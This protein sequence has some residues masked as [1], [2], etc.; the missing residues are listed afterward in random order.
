MEWAAVAP[1][2]RN[3]MPATEAARQVS[4]N[5]PHDAPTQDRLDLTR[6][7]RGRYADPTRKPRPGAEGE[8]AVI[9]AYRRVDPS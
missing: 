8:R 2:N 5:P 1:T 9:E 7:L 4:G 3:R 6:A